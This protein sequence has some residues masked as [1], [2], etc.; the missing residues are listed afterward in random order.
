MIDHSID[1]AHRQA[2]AMERDAKAVDDRM[3]S[4]GVPA[5]WL[6]RRRGMGELR[7]PYGGAYSNLSVRA[8]LEQKDRALASWLA[9]REGKTISGI[10]YKAEEARARQADQIQRMQAETAR[11][12]AARE[13][14][15]Q[16]V[17][18]WTR[19]EMQNAVNGRSGGF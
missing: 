14:R 2:E 10:D 1:H 15:H 17:R 8:I 9:Q 16:P 12:R 5:E 3:Q 19:S 18:L 6:N 4:A 13:A 7:N 11:M